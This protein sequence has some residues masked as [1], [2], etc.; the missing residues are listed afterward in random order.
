MKSPILLLAVTVIVLSSCSSAYRTGQTPDDVYFSP[1]PSAD[2]YVRVESRDNRAYR[3][4]DQ[5]YNYED[6]YLRMRVQNRYRWSALDDYYLSNPYAYN[7]YANYYGGWYSPFNSYWAWNNYYNPY[8]N[9]YYGNI[10]II[11]NPGTFRQI[12]GRPVAFNPNSYKSNVS[13]NRNI[14]RNSIFS[15]NNSANRYN[16][17]N[18]SSNSARKIF[19]NSNNNYSGNNNSTPSRSYNPS[20]SGSSSGGAARSSGGGGGGVSRPGR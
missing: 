2:E 8:Y 1:A 20:S 19:T 3:G 16:N 14:P 4:T 6:N 12:P 13:A 9:P 7:Y 10:I 5:Y 15:G 17:S 18:S 11:K